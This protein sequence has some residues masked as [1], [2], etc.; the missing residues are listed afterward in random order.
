M[1][2]SLAEVI[3]EVLGVQGPGAIIREAAAAV[4][5]K[6]LATA[7]LR[8]LD[9]SRELRELLSPILT[10]IRG[11][12]PSPR[13]LWNELREQGINYNIFDFYADYRAMPKMDAPVEFKAPP[14]EI[15]GVEYKYRYD[16]AIHFDDMKAGDKP[17]IR[18]DWA[19]TLETESEWQDRMATQWSEGVDEMTG[20]DPKLKGRKAVRFERIRVN[21]Y[22]G[23]APH[24]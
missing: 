17:E 1:L 8:K 23:Y 12:A 15:D 22:T 19:N 18:S 10:Q 3:L 7:V 16:Y 9:M 13:A 24:T 11:V 20:T 5:A 6:E 21:V 4:D 14:R 2:P